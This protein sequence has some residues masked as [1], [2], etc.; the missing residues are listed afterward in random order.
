M[1]KNHIIYAVLCV[2]CCIAVSCGKQKVSPTKISIEPS[3]IVLSVGEEY[4][5]R[6][7]V[8]NSVNGGEVRW[9]SLSPSV[10]AVDRAGKV[11]A[12][13]AGKTYITASA[14]GIKCGCQVAVIPGAE[15]GDLFFKPTACGLEDGSSWD[16]AGGLQQL[17]SMLSSTD[18]SALDGHTFYLAEGEYDMSVEGKSICM[19]FTD[20][21]SFCICGGYPT[22]AVGRDL[23]GRDV[24]ACRTWFQSSATCDNA[25][26]FYPQSCILGDITFD[27]LHIGGQQVLKEVR[28]W[29]L[30]LNKDCKFASEDCCISFRNCQF[31]GLLSAE[32]GSAGYY[33]IVDINCANANVSFVSCSF[34]GNSSIHSSKG[35][36]A[37]T[38]QGC[39]KTT[40]ENCTFE[41]NSSKYNGGAISMLLDDAAKTAV[42]EVELRHCSFVGNAVTDQLGVDSAGCGG[43]IYIQGVKANS[44]IHNVTI[45]DCTFTGNT[46][47]ATGGAI[48][49]RYSVNL[50]I[51]NSLFNS[52]IAQG[53]YKISSESPNIGGGA[54]A[55]V[56]AT[57]SAPVSY[58]DA[59]STVHVE[60]CEFRSNMGKRGGALHLDYTDFHCHGCTFDSNQALG[61]GGGAIFLLNAHLYA[62]ACLFTTNYSAAQGGGAVAAKSEN[63]RYYFA[64]CTFEGNT[65]KGSSGQAV[66]N[67]DAS[68][69]VSGND[70]NFY[71]CTFFDNGANATTSTVVS[72]PLCTLLM[73]NCTLSEGGTKKEGV[74]TSVNEG[75]TSLVNNIILDAGGYSLASS[76][77]INSGGSNIYCMLNGVAV[78]L[79]DAAKPDLADVSM[80]EIF[81]SIRTINKEGKVEWS[82]EWEGLNIQSSESVKTYIQGKNS[83]FYTWLLTNNLFRRGTTWIPGSWQKE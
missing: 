29:F 9:E 42:S 2:L 26:V 46:A 6:A 17:C 78:N 50:N 15:E 33:G 20:A 67:Y 38:I 55:N 32:D 64:N 22:D 59:E 28:G 76:G 37:V 47:K 11:F 63:G 81:G 72:S 45:D 35:G 36:G 69:A 80:T 70:F 19:R 18:G 8:S 48:N 24:N 30:Y 5:L 82:G 73:A 1:K 21:P 79:E 31:E 62:S 58:T 41:N 16:N 27:G 60:N 25:R 77:I 44:Y 49:Y 12:L 54:I 51:K 43:A 34:T 71:D 74:I 10:A 56:S 83:G 14:G 61:N 66:I 65:A 57:T 75:A 52:N 3:S 68:K 40:F 39:R 13:K 7:N 4:Q 53:V 23:K